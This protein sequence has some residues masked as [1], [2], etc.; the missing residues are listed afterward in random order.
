MNRELNGRPSLER[1]CLL[2]DSLLA[3]SLLALIVSALCGMANEEAAYYA[4]SQVLEALLANGLACV[5]ST[6]RNSFNFETF[7]RTLNF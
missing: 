2:A 7:L 3:D 4:G 6:G 1:V 5:N